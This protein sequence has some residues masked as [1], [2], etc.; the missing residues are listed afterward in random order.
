MA[1]RT[2]PRPGPAEAP[3]EARLRTQKEPRRESTGAR[4]SASWPRSIVERGR[5]TREKVPP[6]PGARPTQQKRE[7][8]PPPAPGENARDRRGRQVFPWPSRRLEI[9]PSP[10]GSA[11]PTVRSRL[12]FPASRCAH[13]LARSLRADRGRRRARGARGSLERAA[14]TASSASPPERAEGGARAR[15]G[16][17]TAGAQAGRPSTCEWGHLCSISRAVRVR[18][19]CYLAPLEWI[20]DLRVVDPDFIL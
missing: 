15:D 7:G 6:P 20:R 2:E 14:C 11:S 4:E 3:R 13:S 19:P 10:H 12:R 17:E 9:L 18:A 1:A 5:R 8:V 16:G